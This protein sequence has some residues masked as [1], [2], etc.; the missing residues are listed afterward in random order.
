MPKANIIKRK[1]ALDLM[2]PAEKTRGLPRHLMNKVSKD[3]DGIVN[4]EQLTKKWEDWIDY[5]SVDFD[6]ESRQE[7]IRIPKEDNPDESYFYNQND[8]GYGDHTW[9]DMPND[10]FGSVDVFCCL[11]FINDNRKFNLRCCITFF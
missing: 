5:W 7:I 4:T 9:I 11:R 1:N 2:F 6:F 10:G 3:K 8:L